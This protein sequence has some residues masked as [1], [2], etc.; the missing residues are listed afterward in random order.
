MIDPC[1]SCGGNRREPAPEQ[2]QQA[3]GHARPPVPAL[4]D[5]QVVSAM[6]HLAAQIL[7]SADMRPGHPE[8]RQ[9]VFASIGQAGVALA[10]LVQHWHKLRIREAETRP[11]AIDLRSLSDDIR[12]FSIPLAAQIAMDKAEMDRADARSF[13]HWEKPCSVVTSRACPYTDWCPAA[14]RDA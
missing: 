9:A 8:A 7:R 14:C 6:E 10:R 5:R 4:D 11:V 3:K 2:C 12:Q 13:K 1:M